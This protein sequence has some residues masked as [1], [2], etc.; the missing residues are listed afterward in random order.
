MSSQMDDVVHAAIDQLL[1]WPDDIIF[2]G[3]DIIRIIVKG[4]RG[5]EYLCSNGD[6]LVG[7]LKLLVRLECCG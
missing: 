7:R 6:S 5:N 4:A 3:I 2:P 1:Q